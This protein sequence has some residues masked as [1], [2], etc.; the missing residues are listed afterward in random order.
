M[1]KGPQPK[2]ILIKH[3]LECK[4]DLQPIDGL[5]L[6]CVRCLAV[7]EHDFEREPL[8]KF[9]RLGERIDVK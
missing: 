3:C 5:R 8:A 6:V 2:G 1:K 9:N 4:T 7:Q